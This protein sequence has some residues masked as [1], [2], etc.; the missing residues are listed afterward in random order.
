MSVESGFLVQQPTPQAALV[1]RCPQQIIVWLRHRQGA[2]DI[3]H[4]RA[5]QLALD[6]VAAA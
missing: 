5:L 6:R 2:L 3:Q 4:T 1:D